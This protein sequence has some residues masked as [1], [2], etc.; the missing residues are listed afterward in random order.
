MI[1][2]LKIKA[3]ASAKMQKEI[4]V[5]NKEVSI[6]A[7]DVKVEA[8]KAQIEKDKAS[9][10]ETDCKDALAKVQPIYQQAVAAVDKLKPSDVTELTQFKAATPSV[11]VV[12]HALCLFFNIPPL[13]IKA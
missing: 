10:I 13:K 1:P 8:D 9:A 12:A 11:A 7:A 5:Q 6:I 3:D 4:E 2:E